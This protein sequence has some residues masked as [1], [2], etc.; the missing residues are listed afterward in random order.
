[1]KR[2]KINYLQKPTDELINIG[3]TLTE[4]VSAQGREGRGF[5]SDCAKK[6]FFLK[7]I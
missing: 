3:Y 7:M 5:D 6:F 1:M 4:Y 2:T